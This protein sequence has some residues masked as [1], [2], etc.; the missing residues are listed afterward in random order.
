MA[1]NSFDLTLRL[2]DLLVD[3][4]MTEFDSKSVTLDEMKTF[5]RFRNFNLGQDQKFVA[6]VYKAYEEKTKARRN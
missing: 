6:A 4:A 1:L 2:N 5:I 3:K